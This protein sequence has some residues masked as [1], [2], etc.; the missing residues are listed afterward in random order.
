MA[1]LYI[2]AEKKAQGGE[3]KKALQSQSIS[4]WC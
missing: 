2:Y 4:I 3:S 1:F